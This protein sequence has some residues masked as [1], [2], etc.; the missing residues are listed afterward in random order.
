MIRLKQDMLL[1]EGTPESLENFMAAARDNDAL[2]DPDH[3][4]D[5]FVFIQKVNGD[6]RY[7]EGYLAYHNSGEV[8]YRANTIAYSRQI[9]MYAWDKML[10]IFP[11]NK[12]VKDFWLAD[13]TSL[14][15][16]S[17]ANDSYYF[18]TYYKQRIEEC[19]KISQRT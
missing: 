9:H 16:D 2:G 4:R 14:V 15:F 19:L 13:D 7:Y 5:R 10:A 12:R 6:I 8:R 3:S 18:R 11:S 17:V 1:P